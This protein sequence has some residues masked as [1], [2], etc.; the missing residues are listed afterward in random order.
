MFIFVMSYIQSDTCCHLRVPPFLS[1]KTCSGRKPCFF[2]FCSCS[3]RGLHLKSFFKKKKETNKSA[4]RQTDAQCTF[5]REKKRCAQRRRGC[6]QFLFFCFLSFL[7]EKMRFSDL[8]PL[9][10]PLVALVTVVYFYSSWLRCC[11]CC[12]C[13]P[14]VLEKMEANNMKTV[15]SSSQ[16]RPSWKSTPTRAKRERANNKIYVIYI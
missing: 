1:I 14:H 10:D 2:V 8:F 12:C 15:P 16:R 5:K 3:G 4:R 7:H 13:A 11:C 9:D 6:E